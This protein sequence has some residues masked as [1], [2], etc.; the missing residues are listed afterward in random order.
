MTLGSWKSQLLPPPPHTWKGLVGPGAGLLREA[1]SL[2]RSRIRALRLVGPG[3]APQALHPHLWEGSLGAACQLGASCAHTR[4]ACRL[5][6]G[7][8][9]RPIAAGLR[10]PGPQQAFLGLQQGFLKTRGTEMPGICG[11][12]G[13]QS[14]VCLVLG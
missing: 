12:L 7:V 5:R 11:K 8:T 1:C 13:K 10:A 6:D 3:D 4:E 2:Q 9:Q 14:C